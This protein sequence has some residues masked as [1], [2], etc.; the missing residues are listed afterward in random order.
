MYITSNYGCTVL[1]TDKPSP[2]FHH[3]S[4][5]PTLDRYVL[6]LACRDIYEHTMHTP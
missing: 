5:L 3:P 2:K 1:G 4:S 6:P